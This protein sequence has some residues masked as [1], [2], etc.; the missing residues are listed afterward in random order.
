MLSK[1]ANCIHNQCS[2]KWAL[3]YWF[4]LT[5]PWHQDACTSHGSPTNHFSS[6]CQI[7]TLP[8]VSC[9]LSWSWWTPRKRNSRTDRRRKWCGVEFW[10]W[11]QIA[12]RKYCCWY[13]PLGNQRQFWLRQ[14]L[15]QYALCH[16]V[17]SSLHSGP[18]NLVIDGVVVITRHA[19][20]DAATRAAR[21]LPED[22]IRLC[23]GI[24]D[25]H[26]LLEDLERAL[27]SAGAIEF[28][29]VQNRYVQVVKPEGTD[30]IAQATQQ[31]TAEGDLGHNKWEWLIS[32]PGKVI[33]FGEHAVVYGVV[34]VCFCFPHSNP[35]PWTQKVQH[36]QPNSNIFA[37]QFRWDWSCLFQTAIAASLD[38][39]CYGLTSPRQDQRLSVHFH[40]IDNF[41]YEWNIDDL[42]WDAVTSFTAD[43]RPTDLDQRLTAALLQ[44]PLSQICDLQK[45]ARYASLAFLYLYMSLSKSEEQWVHLVFVSP[46]YRGAKIMESLSFLDYILPLLPAHSAV[47]GP[48]DR[49]NSLAFNFSAR[50]TLPVGAGLGSSASFSVCAA[51]AVLLLLRHINIPKPPASSDPST[52]SHQGRRALPLVLAQDVNHWAFMSEK[53]LHGNPSGVDNSVAVFGGALAYT[54]PGFAKKSGMEVIQGSVPDL[55]LPFTSAGAWHDGLRADSNHSSSY[56]RTPKCPETPKS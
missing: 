34:S 51:T 18:Q 52:V 45:H 23:V 24:E 50:A 20:I 43:K 19:S 4:F 22:L 54:R 25:P 35:M 40:D 39:R 9:Q 48:A 29:E 55:S 53:I 5:P 8:R 38:L 7:S 6:R 28:N 1:L 11:E 30:P 10:N 3:A 56:S 33:L 42:P 37:K 36:W 27:L 46:W 17:S 49:K 14:Q 2:R 41:Y 31:F 32:S 16:V 44:G 15:N 12:Q 21:G 13:T 26:D 47:H